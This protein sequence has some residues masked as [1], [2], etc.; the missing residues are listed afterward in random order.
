[1]KV[2]KIDKVQKVEEDE[3]DFE[4]LLMEKGEEEKKEDISS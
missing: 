2:K 1:M 3:D 4:K